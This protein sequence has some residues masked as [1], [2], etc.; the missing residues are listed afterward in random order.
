MN[1]EE[2]EIVPDTPSEGDR[3]VEFAIRLA[4]SDDVVK[5]HDAARGTWEPTYRH[6]ISQEQIAI[7][8]EDLLSI[9]AITRQIEQ[10]EGTYVLALDGDTV[11]GF[12]YVNCSPDDPQRY[13]LHRLYV[14][15]STQR[16]GVGRALLEWVERYV[17]D[18]GADEL[19]LNVNRYN[20][21][22]DFYQK[23]GYEIID[24]VDLPYREYWLNDYVMR[25]Q[26]RRDS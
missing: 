14:R 16:G 7:M 23:L 4:S 17:F 5:I 6:I 19:L 9:P 10:N 20:S 11:V 8:F 3:T 15:P 2:G 26:K 24:T 1:A 18:L 13:K 22:V 12:A 21:A 25:K